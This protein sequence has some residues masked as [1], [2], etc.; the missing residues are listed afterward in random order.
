MTGRSG[1]HL[2]EESSPGGDAQPVLEVGSD[3]G[4]DCGAQPGD[5]KYQR[6]SG[7][8]RAVQ[9]QRAVSQSDHGGRRVDVEAAHRVVLHAV[10]IVRLLVNHGGA[11]EAVLLV[12]I[13]PGISVRQFLG[14]KIPAEFLPPGRP[15]G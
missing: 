4:G 14:H 8:T 5:L 11:G 7:S 6:P 10:N 9:H 2:G 13:M 1:S 3:D 12:I 15:G